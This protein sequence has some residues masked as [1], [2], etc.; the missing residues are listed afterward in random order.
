MN[1]KKNSFLIHIFF[2]SILSSYYLFSYFIFGEIILSGVDDYLDSEIIYNY[3]MG[4]F[5]QG[6]TQS[7]DLLLSGEYKW[8]Y[9]TRIFYPINLIYSFFNL[10]QAYWITDILVRLVAYFSFYRLAKIINVSNFNSALAGALYASVFTTSGLNLLA[11]H[12]GL[13]LAAAPYI[14]YLLNR[15]KNLNLKNYLT[16][17]FIGINSHFYYLLGVPVFFFLYLILKKKSFNVKLFFQVIFVFIFS[18]ILTN[19]NLFYVAFFSNEVF[20]RD[21]WIY[22]SSDL[23]TNILIFFKDIIS[24][25]FH[26]TG[27]LDNKFFYLPQFIDRFPFF[28]IYFSLFLMVLIKRK[29]KFLLI[30]NIIFLI[31]LYSFFERT[32]FFNTVR[33]N[34]EFFPMMNSV[35][36]SRL[37]IF[38][39]FIF[40]TLFIVIAK[41]KIKYNFILIFIMFFSLFF[42]QV[43]P[44]LVPLTKYLISYNSLDEIE[45]NQIKYNFTAFR[46]VQVFYDLKKFYKNRKIQKIKEF[47]DFPSFENYYDYE[48]LSFVKSIVKDKRILPVN[49]HP[50]KLIANDIKV[51]GGYYQFYPMNYKIQFRKIIAGELKKN[52]YQKNYF[53]KM[54]HRL[55]AFTNNKTFNNLNFKEA[56]FLGA[57]YVLANHVLN[58]KSLKKV[59]F[60][61]NNSKKYFLYKIIIN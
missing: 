36:I 40:I 35:P 30:F 46:Y 37:E 31:L 32:E 38:I 11:T 19:L 5:Y 1:I 49:I 13:G 25:P 51:V 15:D 17:I 54:G 43:G 42:F 6:D 33:N 57:D 4:R 23:K 7:I 20:N 10:E 2:L 34:F 59:C 44:T 39:P 47:D 24:W 29:K 53:D 18:T 3:V 48:N 12:Y 21:F 61:C 45:K 28:L 14:I 55:Y 8:Y 56:S 9:F 58:N 27:F 26:S 16:L 52:Q 41:E 50:A 60:E 22:P